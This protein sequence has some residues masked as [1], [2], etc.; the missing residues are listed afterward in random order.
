MKPEKTKIL[1][2]DDDTDVLEFLSYNLKKEKFKVYTS[3]NG[4]KALKIANKK[5]PQLIILDV[6]MPGIDGIETCEE[7]RKNKKL[8][9]SLII[10]LTAR[11]EDYSQIAG[12]EAGA[13]DYIIKPIKPKVLISRIKAILKRYN[14]IDDN[15]NINI[16]QNGDLIINTEKHIVTFKG[17]EIELPKKEFALLKLLASKPD[18]VFSR[19]KIFS[20]IWGDEVIVG[21]RTIDVHIRKIRKKITNDCIK[22]IKG[23]GYKF[24]PDTF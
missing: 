22:T 21:D 12:F 13:D 2:V 16:I 3:E 24:I 17:N 15:T 19:E 6:M 5:I 7:L 8:S 10:F 4:K 20:S 18:K 14:N 9:E 1:L 11:G 23:I